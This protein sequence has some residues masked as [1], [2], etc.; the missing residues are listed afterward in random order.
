MSRLN[1][2]FGSSTYTVNQVNRNTVNRNPSYSIED[3]NNAIIDGDEKLVMSILDTNTISLNQT[4]TRDP[5]R[6]TLLHTAIEM[7]NVI[8]IQKLI[9]LGADLRITNKKGE[10]CADKLSKSH[11]GS[12]IQYISDRSVGKINEL[13]QEV[14]MKNTKIKNLEETVV[15]L[16]DTNNKLYKQK[17]DQDVEIVQLKKRKIELEESNTMLR[18]ASKKS[19]P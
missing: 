15:K 3:L 4:I 5:Y 6:N 19:K 8:I 18:Q 11:L 1:N 7:G 16:E 2:I 9:D 13:T 14:N 17:Q 12:V 10:S